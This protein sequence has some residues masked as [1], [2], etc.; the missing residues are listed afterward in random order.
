[1]KICGAIS[2]DNPPGALPIKAVEEIMEPCGSEE[3]WVLARLSRDYAVGREVVARQIFE[4]D[5]E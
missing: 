1:M 4:Q 2:T 3:F 5:E